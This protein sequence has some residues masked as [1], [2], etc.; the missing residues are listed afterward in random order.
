MT[1]PQCCHTRVIITGQPWR[2]NLMMVSPHCASLAQLAEGRTVTTA[3]SCHV[4]VRLRGLC[5]ALRAVHA[6]S[7]CAHSCVRGHTHERRFLLWRHGS[8]LA[9]C[10][11]RSDRGVV[12]EADGIVE[13][14]IGRQYLC[15]EICVDMCMDICIDMCI[16]ELQVGRQHL[17]TDMC[18]DICID[19][20][21]GMHIH[22]CMN[23]CIVGRQVG[24]QQS[25]TGMCTDLWCTDMHT[26]GSI[27]MCSRR[28]VA[29]HRTIATMPSGSV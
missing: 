1:E 14:Q 3:D 22:M 25:C 16:I 29:D 10:S 4:C 13:L 26:H 21:T 27:L 5:P 24:R 11:S 18:A 6:D 15:M 28:I 2:Q 12:H 8:R 19:S 17:C 9:A 7:A 20:C 23:I